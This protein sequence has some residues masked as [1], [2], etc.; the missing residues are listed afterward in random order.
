MNE[1][2]VLA[3]AGA[4]EIEG[5]KLRKVGAIKN[6]VGGEL[7]CLVRDAIEGRFVMLRPSPGFSASRLILVF[8]TGTSLYSVRH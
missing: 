4:V 7:G 8:P 2:G 1:S 5:P 6:G 3:A